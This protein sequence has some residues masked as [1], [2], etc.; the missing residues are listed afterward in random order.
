MTDISDS[1]PTRKSC[2][3]FS[4]ARKRLRELERIIKDRHG[5]VPCTD[6]ADLY[7]LPVARCFRKIMVASG[8]AA[9]VAE[10]M[11]RFGLWCETWAPRLTSAEATDIVRQMLDESPK[12]DRDDALGA[13]LRLTYAERRRLKITTIGSYDVDR[14]SRKQLAKDRRRERDRLR[15]AEKRKAKGATPRTVYEAR[16]ISR[17]KPWEALNMSRPTYYRRLKAGEIPS[18]TSP[19]PHPLKTRGDAP[20]SKRAAMGQVGGVKSPDHPSRPRQADRRAPEQAFQIID[21]DGTIIDLDAD[22]LV[23]PEELAPSAAAAGRYGHR[24][25]TEGRVR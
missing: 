20:V 18:E 1:T 4:R 12:F 9:S 22:G 7:L 23:D 19:S 5:T 17:T 11:D 16:S 24:P 2:A 8:K 10:V 3:P 13:S 14:K 21:I 6:D 25:Q 15:A